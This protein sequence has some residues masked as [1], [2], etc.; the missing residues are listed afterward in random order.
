MGEGTEK[1]YAVV[2]T[3]R[4]DRLYSLV[5]QSS[6]HE[7]L[8][9][10]EVAE[11]LN[12]AAPYLVYLKT[13]EALFRAWRD[14]GRGQ[15]W[16]IMLRSRLPLNLVRLHL[17]HFLVASLPDGMVAQF[18]FYDPRVLGPYLST[19]APHELAPWFNGVSAFLIEHP[20]GGGFQEFGFDGTSLV[21][22]SAAAAH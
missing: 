13:D 6:A 22:R 14:E 18:R 9:G 2:D 3:A 11:P 10:G 17:K 5:M 1:L 7:C 15:S 12:R 21:D 8:F 20:D 19:C 4:D 16:G